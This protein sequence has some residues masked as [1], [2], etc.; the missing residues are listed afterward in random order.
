MINKAIAS[1]FEINTSID[2]FTQSDLIQKPV[3]NHDESRLNLDGS[4]EPSIVEP[5]IQDNI[6]SEPKAENKIGRLFTEFSNLLHFL[7]NY[8]VIRKSELF[9]KT[10]YLI[11]YP[12]VRAAD[13]DPVIHYIKYGWKEGR[14]PSRYFNTHLYLTIHFSPLNTSFLRNYWCTLVIGVSEHMSFKSQ[15]R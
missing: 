12:D 15:S 10:Y 13:I 5:H 4:A 7:R 2:R 3:N 14:N 8:L 9:N 1:S 6:A 11:T